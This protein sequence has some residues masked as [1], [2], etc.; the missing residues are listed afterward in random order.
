M[1]RPSVKQCAALACDY[2]RSRGFRHG[3]HHCVPE[4]SV[5]FLCE[6]RYE[7]VCGMNIVP[8]G[9]FPQQEY[10]MADFVM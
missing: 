6:T 10:T 4:A 5:R 3:V 7:T 8:S 1:G 9:Q 2:L